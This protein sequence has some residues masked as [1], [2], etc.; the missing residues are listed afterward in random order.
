MTREAWIWCGLAM[1]SLTW[2]AFAVSTGGGLMLPVLAAG[3][4]AMC[5]ADAGARTRTMRGL[6]WTFSGP[7]W[8]SA[9]II[10]GALMLIQLLPAEM[11]LLLA[12]DILAYVEAIAAVSL[13]AAN[14]RLRALIDPVRARAARVIATT[15]RLRPGARAPSAV[16][17]ARRP[18]S[19][20][21][22]DGRGLVFA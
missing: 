17:P 10:G 19:T 18:A 6:G 20:D 12:G 1:L 5:G 21:D 4:C 2:C 22:A 15:V 13:I 8:R 7:A 14:T 16:R 3:L 9:L 11:A